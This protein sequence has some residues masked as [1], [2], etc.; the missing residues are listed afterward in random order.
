[1][2]IQ[3]S[4]QQTLPFPENFYGA[5]FEEINMAGEGGLYAELIRDRSFEDAPFPP[6]LSEQIYDIYDYKRWR[7]YTDQP[8]CGK[9]FRDTDPEHQLNSIQKACVCLE[10]TADCAVGAINYGYFG[11]SLKKRQRYRLSFWGRGENRDA[12]I[13]I[14]LENEEGNCVYADRDFSLSSGWEKYSAILTPAENEEKAVLHIHLLS[15]GVVWLDVVSLMGETHNNDENGF[16]PELMKYLLDLHPRFLRFPGG[17]FVEANGLEYAWDWKKTIG[18]L[19]DRKGHLNTRWRYF[20]ENGL[21]LDEYMKLCEELNAEPL[22]NVYAGISHK[23]KDGYL[24]G[25]GYEYV[26]N[27]CSYIQDTLDALEYLTGNPNTYWGKKRAENGRREPYRIRFIE[28]GNENFGIQYDQ[29][30]QHFYDAIKSVFPFITIIR[31]TRENQEGARDLPGDL[32]LIDKHYYNNAEW[33]IEHW[34]LFSTYDREL[35]P[36]YIGEYQVWFDGKHKVGNGNLYS[37]LAE[38]VFLIG[39]EKNCDVVKMVSYAPLFCNI[40]HKYHWNPNAVFFDHDKIYAIPSY[41]AYQMFSQCTGERFICAGKKDGL[42]YSVTLSEEK[43]CYCVKI[44]NITDTM[45]SVTF[46]GEAL[47]EIL[48]WEM[49]SA[50]NP[51]AENSFGHPRAIFPVKCNNGQTP[52]LSG[53]ISIP[54]FSLHTL[55]VRR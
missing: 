29:W 4:Q 7:F 30:Y 54:P 31:N 41:Y 47:V 3:L 49:L 32:D 39:L 40:H 51:L 19:E 24:A 6:G 2:I 55:R 25:E 9:A 17:C 27:I 13:K 23:L 1:M 45:G 21:G 5:F 11:I 35:P 22:L 43:S 44:V 42:F 8:T 33:F 36:V 10:K 12:C 34:D 46:D 15:Q 26:E 18:R 52:L 53:D 38:A 16:K 37:A 50:E 14:S 20:S 48:D 28:I